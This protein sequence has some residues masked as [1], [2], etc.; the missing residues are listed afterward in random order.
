MPVGDHAYVLTAGSVV[1]G[2]A[3]RVGQFDEPVPG[4]GDEAPAHLRRNAT[5]SRLA[6]PLSMA[7]NAGVVERPDRLG[8]D[9]VRIAYPDTDDVD[10]AHQRARPT[11]AQRPSSSTAKHAPRSPI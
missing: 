2:A 4:L 3:D 11:R 10:S 9:V 6:S 7:K 1:G 5:R 8:G